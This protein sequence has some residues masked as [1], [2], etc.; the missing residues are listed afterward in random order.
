M[1]NGQQDGVGSE[2]I[3][4]S[5]SPDIS[6]YLLIVVG[7]PLSEEYVNQSLA[8]VEKALQCWA[9]EDSAISYDTT[10]QAAAAADVNKV[11]LVHRSFSQCGSNLGLV[12]LINPTSTEVTTE[13]RSL[14]IHNASNKHLIYGG[15]WLQGNGDW[16][17]HNDTFT[18]KDIADVFSE[19]DVDA[20]VLKAS[21]EERQT[22]VV[23]GC[24]W[25]TAS[26]TKQS[27]T[28]SLNLT[29]NPQEV[30]NDSAG[31]SLIMQTIRTNMVIPSSFELLEPPTMGVGVKCKITKPT[32]LI[33]PAGKGDCAFFAVTDFSIFLGGGYCTKSCFW[34]F[35]KH[36]HRID[37]IMAPHMQPDS[38]MGFNSL[39]KRKI[40]EQ[41]LVE[42]EKGTPEYEEWLI[43]CNSPE[44]GVVF[45]NAPE[46]KKSPESLELRTIS[47]GNLTQ[48]LLQELDIKPFSCS[49]NVGK[50]IEPVTLYQ[51]VGIGRLDMFIL[52]PV[53]DSKELKD[54]MLQWSGNKAFSKVKTG[55]KVNGKESE[56][57]SSSAVSICALIVWQPANQHEE[58]VKVLF[59]GNAPQSKILEGLDR[60]KHLEYL[61]H[62]EVTAAKLSKG[63]AQL[64]KKTTRAAPGKSTA[65]ANGPLSSV[66]SKGAASSSNQAPCTDGVHC[67]T[68]PPC[69]DGI[70]CNTPPPCTDGIHCNTPP[71]CTDGIH[72]NTPPPCTDGIHCNTPPPCT[73]GIHCNTPPPC[74][75][76][77]HCN[78]PPPCTD[79]IHCNTPP[80]CTD[81]IHCNTPP[82]CTDGIHCNTPPPCTDGIHCNTPPPCTD[83]IHCNTPPPCTDGIHCN[84]PPPCTDGIHCGT[85]P[86]NGQVDCMDGIH[87]N[88]PPPDNR[89]TDGEHCGTPP[90]EDSY[91]EDACG[92]FKPIEPYKCTDGMNC[93]TPPP[94]DGD[95]CAD[96]YNCNT[97]PP[98]EEGAMDTQQSPVDNEPMATV[99]GDICG[100]LMDRNLPES[101]QDMSAFTFS[102]ASAFCKPVDSSGFGEGE[103]RSSNGRM[104][105]GEISPSDQ[106][107]YGDDSSNNGSP[108]FA[109]DTATTAQS[110]VQADF[111]DYAEEDHGA[112]AST[113]DDLVLAQE[114]KKDQYY[115]H[116]SPLSDN[117]D[118]IQGA[119]D[120]ETPSPSDG[121]H[122]WEPRIE[123][124]SPDQE[125]ED[126]YLLEESRPEA[127]AHESQQE[128]A[129]YDD[130]Q[131]PPP[132][133]P[134]DNQ[135]VEQGV[136]LEQHEEI[137]ED[138]EDTS[139][140]SQ[141]SEIEVKPSL[142]AP[143]EFEMRYDELSPVPQPDQV[144]REDIEEVDQQEVHDEEKNDTESDI[145]DQESLGEVEATPEEGSSDQ[146]FPEDP[147]TQDVIQPGSEEMANQE[148]L[149]DTK[150]EPL[151]AEIRGGPMFEI[152]STE[153]Q[154]DDVEEEMEI[155]NQED[156]ESPAPEEDQVLDQVVP[157]QEEQIAMAL[158]E[159]T[160][161][162]WSQGE[163][164]EINQ[165]F[166]AFGDIPPPMDQFSQDPEQM[167]QD[168]FFPGP[169]QPE[170]DTSIVVTEAEPEEI[171]PHADFDDVKEV[172]PDEF[173]SGQEE[174]HEDQP[175]A[176][177]NM[178]VTETETEEV[179]RYEGEHFE[180]GFSQEQRVEDS[181]KEAGYT[182]QFQN[183]PDV[184]QTE[185]TEPAEP[186][187]ETLEPSSVAAQEFSGSYIPE[188]VWQPEASAQQSPEPEMVPQPIPDVIQDEEQVQEQTSLS[189]P[190]VD[191]LSEPLSDR[192]PDS[193][194]EPI[195][196]EPMDP[197][198][199]PE[200]EPEPKPE[201]EPE[202]DMTPKSEP[203]PADLMFEPPAPVEE[204]AEIISELAAPVQEPP[205]VILEP[206]ESEDSSEQLLPVQDSPEPVI[207]SSSPVIDSPSPVI[208]SPSPVIDSPSPVIDSPS[209]VIDSPS[210]VID[211]P[212][213]VI[214]SPEPVIDSP[215]PVID[216]HSPV[217][218]PEPVFEPMDP[219]MTVPPQPSPDIESSQEPTQSPVPVV[220][221][222]SATQATVAS[223]PEVKQSKAS[224]VSA[225]AATSVTTKTTTKKSTSA[226]KKPGEK[227]KKEISSTKTT[228]KTTK[229]TKSATKDAKSSTKTK[230]STV[231]E[232]KHTTKTQTTALKKPDTVKTTP[233][234]KKR[235]TSTEQKATAEKKVP[236]RKP[237][238]KKS[239]TERK[240]M[241]AEKKPSRSPT[242]KSSTTPTRPQGLNGDKTSVR[243]WER[244]TAASASRSSSSNS[245]TK[246]NGSVDTKPGVTKKLSP[247]KLTSSKTTPKTAPQRPTGSKPAGNGSRKPADSAKKE[248]E[249][250]SRS[251]PSKTGDGK[252]S[253][254]S[255]RPT[256][257]KTTSAAA[258]TPVIPVS[259]PPVYVDLTYIPNHASEDSVNL[260]FFR[261]IRA[262]N[263][264]ISANDKG[265]NQP[266]TTVLD[267]LLEGKAKWEEPDAEVTVIPTYDINTLQEWEQKNLTELTNSKI[268]ISQPASRSVV[269]MKDENFFMYKVEF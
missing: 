60:L 107:E 93:N 199:E 194:S 70:H 265:R 111:G 25:T 223:K 112:A 120:D 163:N 167:N 157:E 133:I 254:S 193:L 105:S 10:L 237:L 229:D 205:E 79:G 47:E 234:A 160:M 184:V 135:N 35:A 58:I 48:Q 21:Q 235:V 251:A 232:K 203:E 73:D 134:D 3:A 131:I 178:V 101:Q 32:V 221:I 139:E 176:Y 154:V 166:M 41:Q 228:T 95:V 117:Q 209:P 15:H 11:G 243:P 22:L 91:A 24:H 98:D 44:V 102:G 122:P 150:E 239:P 61:K 113:P 259:G 225:K 89:C 77:I 269:Q 240:T 12:V 183:Q 97:P 208:D 103:Q 197:I 46:N 182:E 196:D 125:P 244:Q 138:D 27:F 248:T 80:P 64:K 204:P 29:I 42:P 106:V 188:P 159:P 1:D 172:N 52:T 110:P 168:D 153:G 141:A 28:K 87:C 129:S 186:E 227:A 151:E 34:K 175:E 43:K 180:E 6:H 261:R 260:E 158:E 253:D 7:E 4:R 62:P 109:V 53:H 88:T 192:E 164:Q 146:G 96:G 121:P 9:V 100:N 201:P 86:P 219:V 216:S 181:I 16:I 40:A 149:I 81:G 258:K 215:E 116:E 195:L 59:P 74:T 63:G 148:V 174:V 236:E 39:L 218:D 67:N 13:L 198:V 250:F 231:T 136:Q 217:V 242:P 233:V 140:A 132:V 262:K 124:S 56:C 30:K 142:E 33:F 143:Q 187:P 255:K 85:P 152:P 18:L 191:S 268:T 75:D 162:A 206:P 37:A 83:G 72:C 189:E 78:T 82:P 17:L 8:D 185:T 256:S 214:D 118:V 69:T 94:E 123:F 19:P 230:V 171:I 84:T 45:L 55:M 156:G 99:Q 145:R 210:P 170:A 26:V 220:D 31:V 179:I 241:T 76:G 224:D 252:K 104:P 90:P 202:C 137:V 169:D 5:F 238:E 211:S 65:K 207:D 2:S 190:L 267:A 249:R 245:R 226:T 66:N 200:Q 264:V 114:D 36:L 57:L 23:S 161:E 127:E 54:F 38:L 246:T 68:P 50:V 266:S 92:N 119:F 128:Q 20:A 213:P 247:T 126:N 257:A 173:T 71:P 147:Y 212:S 49:A 108:V 165:N 222:V 115:D 144:Y 130:I 51:K 263:Y 177:S 14:L 155:E